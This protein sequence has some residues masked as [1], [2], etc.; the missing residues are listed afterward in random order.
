MIIKLADKLPE[1]TS[2]RSV[3]TRIIRSETSPGASY[4]AACTAKTDRNFID[5]LKVA[6]CGLDESE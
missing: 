3:G 1:I 2:D 5:K 6:V 4:R